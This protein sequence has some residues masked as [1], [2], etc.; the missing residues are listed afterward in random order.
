M[1]WLRKVVKRR[2]SIWTIPWSYPCRIDILVTLSCPLILV[3]IWCYTPRSS[4]IP[5]AVVLFRQLW[6]V[7]CIVRWLREVIDWQWH[8]RKILLY[9]LCRVDIPVFVRCPLVLRWVWLYAPWSSWVSKVVSLFRWLCIVAVT[10][11]WPRNTVEVRW[12]LWIIQTG[13][14]GIIWH[15]LIVIWDWLAACLVVV[16]E[17]NR[18]FVSLWSGCRGRPLSFW[19]NRS[20]SEAHRCVPL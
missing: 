14:P 1:R 10:Q 13:T 6:R 9:S 18:S 20:L 2:R 17:N 7:V 12:G 3:W 16:W 15:S 19:V 8:K 5:Q 11:N 4:R